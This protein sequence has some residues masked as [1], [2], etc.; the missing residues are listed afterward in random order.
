MISDKDQDL[1]QL[2]REAQIPEIDL[3]PKVMS[4]LY[5]EK[6]TKARLIGKR[7]AGLL[8]IAGMLL[9][10]TTAFAASN[11]YYAFKS[12]HGNII[13]EE[14]ILDKSSPEYKKPSRDE[15]RRSLSSVGLSNDLLK[16]GEAAI[17]YVLENNPDHEIDIEWKRVSFHDLTE[18]RSRMAGQPVKLFDRFEGDYQFAHATVSFYPA[19]YENPL[20]DQEEA[21]ITEKL[22]K[23]AEES[24]KGYAMMPIELSKNY[25]IIMSSYQKNSKTGIV[26]TIS[27]TPGKQTIWMPEESKDNPRETLEIK[28]VKMLYTEFATGRSIEWVYDVPGSKEAVHYMIETGLQMNKDQVIKLA[29]SYLD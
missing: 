15:Q 29:E 28:R 18:L 23:Q 26:V 8:V 9:G 1:K 16:E 21:E 7:K 25:W 11:Y 14:K 19:L 24:G 17:F 4:K 5:A 20:T 3:T 2:F 10:V 27:K 22:R 12:K 13:R 6:K